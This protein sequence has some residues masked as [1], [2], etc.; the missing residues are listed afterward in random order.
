MKK[1]QKLPSENNKTTEK[2]KP[3]N[4]NEQTRESDNEETKTIPNVNHSDPASWRT[5]DYH[6]RQILV[7]HGPI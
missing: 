1:V 2:K 7:E 4:E 3:R 6:M 5:C